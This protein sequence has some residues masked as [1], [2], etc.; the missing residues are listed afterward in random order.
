MNAPERIDWLTQRKRGLGGSDLGAILGL[1]K[2]KTPADVWADKTGR[3]PDTEPSLQMRFGS[4][5]EEFVAREYTHQ[6]GRQ[7]QRFN[8]MLHHSTAPIL[9][10]IDRLVIP[11]GQKRASHKTEIRT[12]RLLEA[13]TASAFASFNSEEW[14]EAGTD[15]IPPSYLVQVATY[16][17]LTNCQY[18]DLAVLFGNQE[19]RVYNIRRDMELEQ[20]IIARATEWWNR[21]IINDIAPDPVCEADI[22]MLYPA[23]NGSTVE[24]NPKTLELIAR[25]QELKAQIAALEAELEGDKKAGS[26][27]VLGSLKAFMGEASRIVLGDQELLTWKSAK[28]STV[29]DWKQAFMDAT[30]NLTDAE[31][32]ALL[33]VYQTTKAGARRL[34]LK[35]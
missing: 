6:T 27:G 26:I 33:P 11:E 25:A 8:T 17:M 7:V 16:M 1:S 19:V 4:Y 13:K 34:L 5:A 24:A 28:A 32:A 29:T 18:A 12:D 3:A 30:E 22:K 10:N 21:H 20:E 15:L 23:D 2:F 35:E 9:G 14:G 31:R